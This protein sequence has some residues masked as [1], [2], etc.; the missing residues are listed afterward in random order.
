MIPASGYLTCACAF[1]LDENAMKK[2]NEPILPIYIFS[3]KISFAPVFSDGVIPSLRP[4]VAYALT[5]S[6]KS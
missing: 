3:D 4:T 2:P 5:C 1:T 6:N